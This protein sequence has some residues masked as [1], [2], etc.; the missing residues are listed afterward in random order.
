VRKLASHLA[1][2]FGDILR[3]FKTQDCVHNYNNSIFLCFCQ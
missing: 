2:P 1:S 3:V